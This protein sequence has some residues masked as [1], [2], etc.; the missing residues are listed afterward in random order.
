MNQQAA[1]GSGWTFLSSGLLSGGVGIKLNLDRQ[2]PP[3]AWAEVGL[4]LP[5]LTLMDTVEVLDLTSQPQSL[6]TEGDTV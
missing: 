3:R 6:W 1:K 4:Q 2:G 5:V